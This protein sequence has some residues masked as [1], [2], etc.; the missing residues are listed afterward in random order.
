[1]RHRVAGNRINMPEARRRAA[2]RN[3]MDGLLRYE[4]IKTTEARARAIRGETEHLITI[5]ING[6][7][8]AWGHLR[9]VVDDDHQAE[10][11]WLLARRGYFSLDEEVA[12]N[13]EREAQGKLPLS[14]EGRKFREQRLKERQ[15]E[16]LKIISDRDEAQAALDAARQAMAIQLHA[17]RQ[18]LKQLPNE[19]VVKKVFD[20]LVPRYMDRPGGYTRIVKLGR[21]AG[22]AAEMAQIELV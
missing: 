22:D 18:I 21:R 15:Q 16:L 8:A 6:T 9:S 12:D 2:F 19:L 13:E 7:R 17:R 5:A 3:L 4:R 1:M 20:E 10:E 14:A 11:V